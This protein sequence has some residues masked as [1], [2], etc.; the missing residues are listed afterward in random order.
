M[1]RTLRLVRTAAMIGCVTTGAFVVTHDPEGRL[2]R[3]DGLL[4][5]FWGF[6]ILTLSLVCLEKVRCH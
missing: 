4:M 2:V 3:P 1:T 5:L 6:S